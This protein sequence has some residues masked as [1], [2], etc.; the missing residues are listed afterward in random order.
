MGAP[1]LL[2]QA[3]QSYGDDLE[4]RLTEVLATTL[5]VNDKFCRGLLREIGLEPDE[6]SFSIQTQEGF[7]GQPRLVDLVI[8]GVDPSGRQSATVFVE[9]K[10]NPARRS[11]AYWF[12]EDQTTRQFATLQEQPG[13]KRL[14]GI[15]SEFDVRLLE[16]PTHAARYDPRADGCSKL[17]TWERIRELALETYG[18]GSGWL[19]AA[20]RPGASVPQRFLLEFIRY[21]EMEGDHLGA[22]DD[23]DVFVLAREARSRERIERVLDHAAEALSAQFDVEVAEEDFD[24]DRDAPNGGRRD[25]VSLPA[26]DGTWL[27][28]LLDGG[29]SL[30]IA[31]ASYVD[32]RVVGVPTA[33]A[34]IAWNAGREAS[35]VIKGSE[36]ESQAAKVGLTLYWESTYCNV[37]AAK[38]LLEA[39]GKADTLADQAQTL[40]EW[41]RQS[42]QLGLQ[43]S[44]PPDTDRAGRKAK[45]KP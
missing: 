25:W 7:G 42:V 28:D 14:I 3:L 24:S 39:V 9:N 32:D 38:P 8:R 19:E 17:V 36:W 21:L 34:G 26:P 12:S 20:R 43:L 22:L 23:E 41:A 10:Y 18:K 2:V 29:I 11:R 33:Y 37:Y 15:A 45:R 40:A 44:K 1:R 35:D 31:D 27:A 30:M 13:T 5:E 6:R 4:D 16:G